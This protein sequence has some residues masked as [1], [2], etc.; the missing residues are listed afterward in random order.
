VLAAAEEAVGLASI[1]DLGIDTRTLA[2][3]SPTRAEAEAA[4]RAGNL[5]ASDVDD[6]VDP[7][8]YAALW[9]RWRGR[10]RDL[11]SACAEF[12]DALLW[13]DVLRLGGARLELLSRLLV[14]AYSKLTST[15]IPARVRHRKLNVVYA[16]TEAAH[17]VGYSPLDPLRLPKGLADA[18]YCFDGRSTREALKDID[19]RHRLRLSPAVVRKLV[20]F[21]LLEETEDSVASLHDPPSDPRMHTLSSK[22]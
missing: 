21:G 3:L 9:G 11:Y 2:E 15:E 12:S 7:E 4:S 8:R 6:Q 13:P 19:E 22:G 14:D 10:E 1:I 17:V 18:L 16:S 5:I 20:D